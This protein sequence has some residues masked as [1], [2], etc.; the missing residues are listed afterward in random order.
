MFSST[1]TKD[2]EQIFPPGVK[3][4]YDGESGSDLRPYMRQLLLSLLAAYHKLLSDIL[5]PVPSGYH[6]P[7]DIDDHIT[8]QDTINE[9]GA[10][11]EWPPPL[12]WEATVLWIR[13][14]GMNMGWAIN[15]YRPIQV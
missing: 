14:L 15:E 11:P 4:L 10:P 5:E 7:P 2:E 6:R 8:G 1:Q 9:D 3:K 13:T 12:N